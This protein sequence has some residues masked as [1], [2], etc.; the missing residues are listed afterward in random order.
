[1][2]ERRRIG[3]QTKHVLRCMMPDEEST[4]VL[5]PALAME[6][7]LAAHL[8]PALSLDTGEVLGKLPL[9]AHPLRQ[10]DTVIQRPPIQ[11]VA[12]LIA[13]GDDS[14]RPLSQPLGL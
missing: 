14:I 6:G 13:H 5:L 4:L 3:A 8:L 10:S 1:M 9:P 2:P 7:S 11:D 12:K